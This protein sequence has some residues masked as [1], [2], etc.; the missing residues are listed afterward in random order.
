MVCVGASV[1]FCIV[2]CFQFVQICIFCLLFYFVPFWH[3]VE[4]YIRQEKILIQ[5]WIFPETK[6][7]I[8]VIVHVFMSIILEL[9][10]PKI[11]KI[12][13]WD[14]SKEKNRNVNAVHIN[15]RCKMKRSGGSETF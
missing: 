13:S 5:G 11:A 4:N 1:L 6:L 9:F 3:L 7:Q 12:V 14:Y 8:F 2:F 15:R 10:V